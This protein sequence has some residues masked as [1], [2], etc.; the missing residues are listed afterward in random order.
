MSKSLNIPLIR[1]ASGRASIEEPRHELDIATKKT[2]ADT[3]RQL[4]IKESGIL[5]INKMVT[6]YHEYLALLDELKLPTIGIKEGNYIL[7]NALVA[8]EI[9]T[10]VL[11]DIIDIRTGTPIAITYPNVAE[12]DMGEKIVFQ[13][14]KHNWIL[15]KE[16]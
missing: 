3:Y 16:A 6:V 4:T 5:P 1:G 9:S 10:Q 12:I 2:K 13:Y 8:C 11:M 7:L 15:S 14:T